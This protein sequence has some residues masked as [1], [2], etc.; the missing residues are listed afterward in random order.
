MNT[1][2]IKLLTM[3][4]IYNPMGKNWDFIIRGLNFSKCPFCAN[5]YPM[6]KDPKGSHSRRCPSCMKYYES[7]W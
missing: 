1:I 5:E 7:E 3:N 2:Q 6:R 4:N